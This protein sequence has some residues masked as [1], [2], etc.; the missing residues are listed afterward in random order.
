MGILSET[1]E[2]QYFEI[3]EEDI[4]NLFNKIEE[5]GESL[6]KAMLKGIKLR[7][8]LDPDINRDIKEQQDL[9]MYRLLTEYLEYFQSQ[10]V[11]EVLLSPL[12]NPETTTESAFDWKN[13]NIERRQQRELAIKQGI[14]APLIVQKGS[15]GAYSKRLQSKYEQKNSPL[16]DV[17]RRVQNVDYIDLN[18]GVFGNRWQKFYSPDKGLTQNDRLEILVELIDSESKYVAQADVIQAAI[19]NESVSN[20]A[21]VE[22]LFLVARAIWDGQ[23]F[24]GYIEDF[25]PIRY[26]RIKFYESIVGN[27]SP[28]PDTVA[29][30]QSLDIDVL[31]DRQKAIE[32]IS[33]HVD[34]DE[35][36]NLKIMIGYLWQTENWEEILTT[37]RSLVENFKIVPNCK[38]IFD[39][40]N[41]T[42]KL[43]SKTRNSLIGFAKLIDL[44]SIRIVDSW[45]GL[46]K[47]TE[48]ELSNFSEI[49]GVESKMQFPPSVEI[50]NISTGISNANNQNLPKGY[51]TRTPG[52]PTFYEAPILATAPW[53]DRAEI[54]G[55]LKAE[56]ATRARSYHEQELEFDAHN[57]PVNPLGD[58]GIVG[59]GELGK[60]GVN[61][62][63]DPL[64][65]KLD[66]V[67]QE[68]KIL[69]IKRKDNGQWAIP[70]GM[71]DFGELVSATALRELKEETGVE[72]DRKQFA[73]RAKKVYQGPVD[74]RRNTNNAW[75][76]T[77]V[78]H[79]HLNSD[80][81]ATDAKAG[82]DA[83]DVEWVTISPE[84]LHGI[85][86]SEDDSLYANHEEFVQRALAMF[87]NDSGSSLPDKTKRQILRCLRR[88][89]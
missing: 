41:K 52:T 29:Q 14:S 31:T 3:H 40:A 53:A 43:R 51:P 73:S 59:R 32:L 76:V 12:S 49:C 42:H 44:D 13:H 16:D 48:Q 18:D 21:L 75:M 50:S 9:L 78:F 85:T 26:S 24:I 19:Y 6:L 87:Y 22:M 65:T 64:I 27:L 36:R 4:P 1:T 38:D 10:E 88:E 69:V 67:T 84:L 37:E 81:V 2:Q 17:A 45:E 7:I 11:I 8:Y 46:R 60:W 30:L 5:I 72:V 70:G 35:A 20:L 25:D 68:L 74:D 54:D 34:N 56:L 63:A 62:A 33:Q 58:T 89:L 77:S 23:E 15:S 28:Y 61:S 83:A 79:Y 39:Q 57:R 82:D 47:H 71:V 80:E 66:P 55:T 86:R